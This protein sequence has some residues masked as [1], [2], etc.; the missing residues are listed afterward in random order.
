MIKEE[1][2]A[3]LH[4]NLEGL[5]VTTLRGFWSKILG[6]KWLFLD[7][8]GRDILDT[9]WK[10]WNIEITISSLKRIL[11]LGSSAK[12]FMLSNG[13]LV[14]KNTI[15]QIRAKAVQKSKSYKPL[16]F[17]WKC[18]LPSL[19]GLFFLYPGTVTFILF[20]KVNKSVPD[21]GETSAFKEGEVHFYQNFR[22]L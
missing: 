8:L 10:L 4:G 3:L 6:C 1:I 22:D 17:W 12:N 18:T 13:L 20:E 11:Q 15:N 5:G 7:I 16:K 21:Y 14:C 19:V 2:Y 9:R